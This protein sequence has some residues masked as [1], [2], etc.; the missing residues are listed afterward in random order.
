VLLLSSAG[1]EKKQHIG[2]DSSPAA[3]LPAAEGRKPRFFKLKRPVW[4]P[5]RRC[6]GEAIRLPTRNQFA[7]TQKI[8]NFRQFCC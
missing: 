5:K 6:A 8:K 4:P 1:V 7:E 2:V 3:A